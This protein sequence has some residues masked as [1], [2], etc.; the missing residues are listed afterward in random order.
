MEAVTRVG[1]AGLGYWG[2]NLA[3][4]FDEL[5]ELAWICDQDPEQLA[6]FNGRYPKA[7]PTKSFD[8]MVADDAL[9]AV[10]ISTPVPTHYDLVVNTDVLNTAQAAAAVLAAIGA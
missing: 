6:L 7:M 10:V 2:P 5:A 8:E 3:R 9:D 4:N 1:V